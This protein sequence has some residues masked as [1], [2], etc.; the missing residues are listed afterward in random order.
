[1]L[2]VEGSS[3]SPSTFIWRTMNDLLEFGKP[4]GNP[5]YCYRWVINFGL[6]ALRLHHW[7]SNDNHIHTHPYWMFIICLSGSYIDIQE[8]QEDHVEAFTWR[9]R[10]PSHKHKV[11]TEG[12]WTFLITG[13]K[14]HKWYL[15]KNG[16]RYHPN[17]Y[18]KME[19]KNDN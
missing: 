19:N 15:F 10:K 11:I 18:F 2:T 7:I 16:K 9:F 1:M 12:A 4:L 3:P 8:E 6:F 13:P 17:K 5:P 14:L